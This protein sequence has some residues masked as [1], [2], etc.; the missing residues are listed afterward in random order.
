MKLKNNVLFIF[1]LALVFVLSSSMQLS[2]AKISKYDDFH[3]HQLKKN[4]SE[5]G[6]VRVIVKLDVPDIEELTLQST[7]FKTGI[8]DTT[9]IQAA[10]N[11]DLALEEAISITGNIVL[12]QL[13]GMNYKVIRT[14]STIPYIG[15]VVNVEILDKLKTIPEVLDI[16]E[17]SVI[18]LPETWESSVVENMDVSEPKLQESTLLVGADVAWDFGYTGSGWYVAILDSGILTSHEMFQGKNIV[19]HCFALG[20]NREDIA[21]GD[22]PNGQIEMSGPGSAAHYEPRFGHG[23]HVAGI[24]AGNNQS[25]Q[26]GVARGADII[27]VQIFTYFPEE[28]NIGSWVMDQMSALEYIYSQRNNYKIAAVNMS[29]GGYTQYTIYCDTDLRQSAI[30]NL[31]AAGIATIV[32]SGNE[33]NCN[34]V[35][36]P[37]CISTALAINAVD[38]SDNEYIL[39]NWHDVMV[40][41]MAPGVR[42]NSAGGYSNNDYGNRTG[43]SMAAPHVTGAW[44][45]LKQF[46]PN[47]SFEAI[48]MLLQDNGKMI[49]SSKCEGR[50]PKA[51][52]NI[53]DALKTLL[54]VAPPINLSAVQKINRSLLMTEYINEIAWESNPF[55]NNRTITHYNIY[56]SQGEQLNL[57]TQVNSSTF[58][59]L[60]RKV[61]KDYEVTYA[62]SAVDADGQESSPAYFILEFN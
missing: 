4:A 62:V 6:F 50:I 20:P 56:L 59:Y 34:G 33:G 36:S 15:I 61:E 40:D 24:A 12:H 54:I 43:T 25:S 29:L 42:I 16:I 31:R 23:S 1:S 26:F 3:I 7:S 52:I 22:C 11:A 27:A 32:S 37:A 60:H 9:Y 28:N 10:V 49:T 53:G 57:L 13:N 38:K 30:S 2:G 46:D 35:S 58:S 48:L 19:E 45:I 47:M 51:R 21:H 44:A 41:L 18:L 8:T 14:F 39:G 17:D 5:K 55:N